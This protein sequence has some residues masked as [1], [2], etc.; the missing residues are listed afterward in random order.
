M[1]STKQ[2]NQ[3]WLWLRCWKYF[4]KYFN[5]CQ[6]C[7][8]IQDLLAVTLQYV[9][10]HLVLLWLL[11]QNYL[12]GICRLF[13]THCLKRKHHTQQIQNTFSISGIYPRWFD[14][15]SPGWL[16]HCLWHFCFWSGFLCFLL[17]SASNKFN[18]FEAPT[19]NSEI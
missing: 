7:Y 14:E 13:A 11:S 12:H 6:R 16:V 17:S 1:V 15:F 9:M 5:C 8:C 18:T 2:M 3:N 4:W 10:W 19:L